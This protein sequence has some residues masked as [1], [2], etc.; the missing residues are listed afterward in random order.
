MRG[1]MMRLVHLYV[2]VTES[3]TYLCLLLEK[4]ELVTF[5]QGKGING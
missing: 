3:A 5:I 4:C 2:G 1:L